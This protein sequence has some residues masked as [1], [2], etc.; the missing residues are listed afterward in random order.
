MKWLLKL[1]YG[2]LAKA[3]ES[4]LAYHQALEEQARKDQVKARRLMNLCR[5]KPNEIDYPLPNVIRD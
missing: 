3:W 5:Q 4:E 2:Y 1:Y